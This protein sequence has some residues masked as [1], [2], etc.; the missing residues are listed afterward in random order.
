M[1]PMLCISALQKALAQQFNENDFLVYE[2]AHNKIGLI[3]HCQKNKLLDPPV[4]DQVVKALEIGLRKL[5][6]GDTFVRNRGQRAQQAGEDGFWDA[7]RKRDLA[8]VAK[9]FRTTPAELCKEWAYETLKAQAPR[10]EV[11]AIPVVTPIPTIPLSELVPTIASRF[12]IPPAPEAATDPAVVSAPPPP[13][14][15]KAPFF[16]AAAR[17]GEPVGPLARESQTRS[18]ATRLSA[19]GPARTLNNHARPSERSWPFNQLERPG[20]C[21]MPDC[22]WPTPEE[23][24][25][26]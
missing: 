5:P 14:P 15:E 25:S 20:R 11:S 26:R 16:A 23:R 1:S 12:E 2:A 21:F 13:L 24:R 4:A 9:L 19:R 8:A 22:R 18:P 6:A 3:R 7:G 17:T 10:R